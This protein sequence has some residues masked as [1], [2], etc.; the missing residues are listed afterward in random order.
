MKR[1]KQNIANNLIKNPVDLRSQKSRAKGQGQS[2]NSSLGAPL[3]AGYFSNG[4]PN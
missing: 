2:L 3:A 4:R 1:K